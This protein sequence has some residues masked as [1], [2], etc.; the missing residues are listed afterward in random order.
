MIC[1]KPC[2]HNCAKQFIYN[3]CVVSDQ[4]LSMPSPMEQIFRGTMVISKGDS[5]QKPLA[6][7]D[8]PSF[9][10]KA[11]KYKALI[12]SLYKASVL[13]NAFLESEILAFDGLVSFNEL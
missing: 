12:D 11:Q 2:F 1:L 9:K 13:R 7:M 6:I 5:F 3:F 10:D 8:S 4:F